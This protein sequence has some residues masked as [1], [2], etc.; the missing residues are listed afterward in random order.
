MLVKDIPKPG[1]LRYTGTPTI[2]G[3]KGFRDPPPLNGEA[4]MV[5]AEAFVDVIEYAKRLKK[6]QS[7]ELEP[8]YIRARIQQ[9]LE[10]QGYSE[11]EI[12]MALGELGLIAE[13]VT[14]KEIEAYRD[15]IRAKQETMLEARRQ[16]IADE[17]ER[18]R[19]ELEQRRIHELAVQQAAVKLVE[20][21]HG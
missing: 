6:S 4:T 16:R 17:E 21:Q 2:Q 8:I 18:I 19:M 14:Q 13:K 7:S 15:N 1:E 20:A 12:R 3:I 10:N 11:K 9:G 5:A